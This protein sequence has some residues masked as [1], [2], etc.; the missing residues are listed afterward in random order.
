VLPKSLSNFEQALKA[1]NATFTPTILQALG[2]L[3]NEEHQTY[4]QFWI[5]NKKMVFGVILVLTLL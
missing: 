3:K 4:L 2:P 5:L 1:H